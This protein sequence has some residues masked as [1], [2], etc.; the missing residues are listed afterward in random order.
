VF[1]KKT[2]AA[3]GVLSGAGYLLGILAI[4][5]LV[6]SI[7]AQAAGSKTSPMHWALAFWSGIVGN[8]IGPALP[9]LFGRLYHN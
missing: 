3:W 4:V 6:V 9:G 8:M 5:V 2:G 7:V 1:V